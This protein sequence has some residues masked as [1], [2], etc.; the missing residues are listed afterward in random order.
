MTLLNVYNFFYQYASLDGWTPG[1][2]PGTPAPLDRWVLGRLSRAVAAVTE[3]LDGYDAYSA[4]GEIE[5]FVD[6]LSRWYVRR[7][8]RRFWKTEADDDKRAAYSTL[9]RCL[10]T[11]ALLLAPVTPHLSEAL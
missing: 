2:E 11:M 3:A 6:V 1:E 9:Y 4:C 8:R 10:R 7:S 5:G